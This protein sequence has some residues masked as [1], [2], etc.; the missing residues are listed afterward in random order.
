[1]NVIAVALIF[2]GPIFLYGAMVFLMMFDA[3][4]RG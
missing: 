1:M 3:W 4:K 2:V